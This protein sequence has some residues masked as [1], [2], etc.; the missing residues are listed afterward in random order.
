[1]KAALDQYLSGPKEGAAPLLALA[2]AVSGPIS[3]LVRIA[4]RRRLPGE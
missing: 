2:R 4:R 3:G 1:M